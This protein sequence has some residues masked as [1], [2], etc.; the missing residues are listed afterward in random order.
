MLDLNH[1]MSEH[2]FHASGLLDGVLT[3]GQKMG[4]APSPAR[5]ALLEEC[6]PLFA[7]MRV[8]NAEHFGAS[9][10]I[11]EAIEE[12]ESGIRKLAA[13][14][15]GRVVEDRRDGEG[16]CPVCR[17]DIMKFNPLPGCK[18]FEAYFIALCPKCV[19]L[20]MPALEQLGSFA[21]FRT[22]AI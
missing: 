14:G 8:L 12:C 20:F 7:E 6:L 15:D 9:R 21:G 16:A 3:R 13:L 11:A 18:G 1:P 22:D 5:A 17:A 10:F 4:L 19:E 2:I